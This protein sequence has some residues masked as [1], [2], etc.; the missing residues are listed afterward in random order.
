MA[1]PTPTSRAPLLFL[2][3]LALASLWPVLQNLHAFRT[4]FYFEDEWDLIDLWDK[5]G[6]TSWV[7]TVFAENFVPLFK[8][9][10]GGAIVAFGGSYFALVLLLWL[11]HAANVF[12][13]S[14][15]A[16]RLGANWGGTA[17]AGLIFGLA[18]INFETLGWTVQWSAV[19]SLFF[20][21]LAL[22]ALD[23][24]TA[25]IGRAHV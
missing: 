11:T 25:E 18:W 10:W 17:L 5:T 20:L 19:L 13:L 14:R 3:A 22:D 16:T 24:R 1:K 2:F 12:L 8:A 23:G 15:I 21:L 9:A 4:L 7:G 6:F